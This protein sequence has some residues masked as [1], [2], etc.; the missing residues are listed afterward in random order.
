MAADTSPGSVPRGRA[1]TLVLV[2]CS[3]PRGR[4]IP[5]G[6]T[7]LPSFGS[8]GRIAALGNESSSKQTVSGE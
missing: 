3:L 4:V 1:G 7:Q 6:H 5:G 8:L 2:V